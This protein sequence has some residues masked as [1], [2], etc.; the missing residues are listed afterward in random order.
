MD[1]HV[2][3][4]G[5]LDL[6]IRNVH[7]FELT[8]VGETTRLHCHGPDKRVVLDRD[9]RVVLTL[10]G[11]RMVIAGLDAGAVIG[12]LSDA[13]TFPVQVKPHGPHEPTSESINRVVDRLQPG[14]VGPHDVRIDDPPAKG[15]LHNQ[16]DTASGQ[17]SPLPVPVRDPLEGTELPVPQLLDE[18][19]GGELVPHGLGELHHLGVEW[20]PGV[21]ETRRDPQVVVAEPARVT[22][23]VEIDQHPLPDRL[24][25]TGDDPHDPRPDR[26]ADGRVWNA[27]KVRNE[28]ADVATGTEGL[29]DTRGR[30]RTVP[31]VLVRVVHVPPDFE[32]Q[33]DDD[34]QRGRGNPEDGRHGRQELGADLL[35][36]PGVHDNFARHFRSPETPPENHGPVGDP[37]TPVEPDH[38]EDPIEGLRGEDVPTPDADVEEHDLPDEGVIAHIPPAERDHVDEPHLPGVGRP[39]QVLGVDVHEGHAEREHQHHPLRDRNGGP[40][41]SSGERVVTPPAEVTHQGVGGH[42]HGTDHELVP[43]GGVLVVQVQGIVGRLAHEDDEVDVEDVVRPQPLPQAGHGRAGPPVRGGDQ[44]PH[45]EAGGAEEQDQGDAA[46]VATHPAEAEQEADGGGDDQKAGTEVLPGH[47]ISL[48]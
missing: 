22:P 12:Q 3:R 21:Q 7:V 26:Q 35:T 41:L 8:L 16:V 11:G 44:T 31:E 43:V 20:D 46:E 39:P 42:G 4:H 25:V 37:R 6:L 48:H 45:T 15:T 36:Q 32:A 10:R 40:G 30:N 28:V 19:V 1:T 17:R 9:G 18:R 27:R 34:E 47:G 38:S 14:V 33:R 5:L 2:V 29:E 23:P 24:V 13:S